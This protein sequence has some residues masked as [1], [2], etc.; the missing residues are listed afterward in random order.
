[1][2][3]KTKKVWRKRQKRG[4]IEM[5]IK[6][7]ECYCLVNKIVMYYH[8]SKITGYLYWRGNNYRVQSKEKL[9]INEKVSSQPFSLQG[10]DFA[11]LIIPLR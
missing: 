5:S 9:Q 11:A 2:M 4:D 7:S 1:M 8:I 10:R 3:G 6:A